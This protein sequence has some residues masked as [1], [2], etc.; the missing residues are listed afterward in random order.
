MTVGLLNTVVFKMSRP[1]D[2]QNFVEAISYS[3]VQENSDMGP[4]WYI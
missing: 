1:K 4:I 2:F 3:A